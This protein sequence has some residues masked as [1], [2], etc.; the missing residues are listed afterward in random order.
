M[1][2]ASAIMLMRSTI[3][4]FPASAAP[5]H[6]RPTVISQSKALFDLTTSDEQLD[7]RDRT[8]F[9]CVERGGFG[10]V[11]EGV[12]TAL[13]L[14]AALGRRLVLMSCNDASS[15]FHASLRRLLPTYRN[16]APVN[17]SRPPFVDWPDRRLTYDH[18]PPFE[19]VKKEA[20]RMN[21][22]P[23]VGAIF[24]RFAGHLKNASHVGLSLIKV[25]LESR[26]HPWTGPRTWQSFDA[27]LRNLIFSRM[28]LSVVPTASHI[29]TQGRSADRQLVAVHIRTGDCH[30][31]SSAPLVP[32]SSSSS[33]ACGGP[34]RDNR[35]PDGHNWNTFFECLLERAQN[36]SGTKRLSFFIATD[37][38]PAVTLAKAHLPHVL[39]A[40]SVGDVGHIGVD[41]SSAALTRL[42]TDFAVLSH[43]DLL[44]AGRSSLGLLAA[45]ASG[46]PY[47][48]YGF[49]DKDRH[50]AGGSFACPI[51]AARASPPWFA[52]IAGH[53]HYR[54]A[55][56]A[57]DDYN[58]S[59]LL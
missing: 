32:N 11:L 7:K 6:P 19:Q 48:R 53:Q 45:Q 36:A 24:Q 12:S 51:C 46:L 52:T 23:D 37:W 1:F 54:E 25:L 14:A 27:Y 8:I 57:R 41:A 55:S 43:A 15:S 56:N 17:D 21:R 39:T 30:N 44:F 34:K 29:L 58:S 5:M 59:S 18:W 35:V 28:D 38:P 33:S 22:E 47:I 50:F 42:L 20:S 31:Q 9:Y 4:A 2:A 40:A 3:L 26:G 10:N 49:S 16:L 13:G